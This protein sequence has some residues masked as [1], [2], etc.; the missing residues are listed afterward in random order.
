MT[1][2]GGFLRE[3]EVSA[4]AECVAPDRVYKRGADNPTTLTVGSGSTV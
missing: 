1:L 4:V 3:T 2:L